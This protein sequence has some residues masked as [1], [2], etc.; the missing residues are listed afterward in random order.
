MEN[1]VINI[2]IVVLIAVCVWI[3]I[4]WKDSRKLNKDVK[5]MAQQHNLVRHDKRARELCRA[6]HLLNPNVTCG[7][8]YII[9]H[10]S[11]EQEPYIA[12]WFSDDP[13][14]TGEEIKSALLEI[15]DVHHEAKYSAL[16]R[17]E[18]PSIEDQLDAAY[19][20]RHGNPAKQ[21]EIDEQI[22]RVK[23]KYPKTDECSI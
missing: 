18:Y 23:E 21:I 20:A 19:Q 4:M 22:S 10:D 16:R 9:R 15:S 17:A 8:D 7:T 11:P 12:E 3:Y 14:P 2:I 5:H 1:G 13:R 6:I